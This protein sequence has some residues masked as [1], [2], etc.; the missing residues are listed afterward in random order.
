[1]KP[2][3]GI[4]NEFLSPSSL[5]L[6]TYTCI[7]TCFQ[8]HQPTAQDQLKYLH[9]A[10]WSLLLAKTQ[11]WKQISDS[12]NTKRHK[13]GKRLHIYFPV[14]SF[15]FFV[16]FL[17]HSYDLSHSVCNSFISA[18]VVSS[19]TFWVCLCVCVCVCVYWTFLWRWIRICY[20][21]KRQ[22]INMDQTDFHLTNYKLEYVYIYQT[23]SKSVE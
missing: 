2:F 17:F 14:P 18:Y 13:T 19:F 10:S 6:P 1:M 9:T 11:N 4:R 21:Q 3:V 12:N 23:T 22:R 16:L 20:G 5:L 7:Y 15:L 8:L